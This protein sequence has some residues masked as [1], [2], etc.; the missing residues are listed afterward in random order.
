MMDYISRGICGYNSE[1]Y[2]TKS[3]HEYTTTLWSE[4]LLILSNVFLLQ[5]EMKLKL[6]SNVFEML[7]QIHTN[8]L[9]QNR[10]VVKQNHLVEIEHSIPWLKQVDAYQR[11]LNSYFVKLEETK[12]MNERSFL[13]EREI[14]TLRLVKLRD[15]TLSI[16]KGE[17]TPKIATD[18]VNLHKKFIKMTTKEPE[19]LNE[20]SDK[21]IINIIRDK[22]YT[23]KVSETFKA[24]ASS[25][26][27][28]RLMS[29]LTNKIQNVS[30]H[31]SF[32]QELG[33]EMTNMF[34]EAEIVEAM[35]KILVLNSK[36]VNANIDKEIERRKEGGEEEVCDGKDV[37]HLE[38]M[39]GNHFLCQR[40]GVGCRI[41][42]NMLVH[43]LI[44]LANGKVRWTCLICSRQF[45][46]WYLSANVY[47]RHIESH[48]AE[49]GAQTNDG[50]SEI[51]KPWKAQGLKN[52]FSK[53]KNMLKKKKESS[54]K[55]RFNKWKQDV[56]NV[57]Q[58]Y[59]QVNH[60]QGASNKPGQ[61]VKKGGSMG[62]WKKKF[63]N[64][65]PGYSGI[66]PGANQ[67]QKAGNKPVQQGK[68]WGSGGGGKKKR[69]C[70][71]ANP[72]YPSANF[73]HAGTNPGYAGYPNAKKKKK[74]WKR[75]SQIMKGSK[76]L[77]QQ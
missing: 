18:E 44:C 46:G 70:P 63:P 20:T 55:E 43:S 77:H 31:N 65:K 22:V 52:T 72:G 49:L 69:W 57:A 50:K 32:L 47:K 73:G 48:I 68:K 39:E 42:K 15:I 71:G 1:I 58:L 11:Y 66:H 14:L 34:S 76:R 59:S 54:H 28:S 62:G 56:R 4:C 10:E 60:P 17:M 3:Y 33:Q 37:G 27:H 61:Q 6:T 24:F 29:F 21:G 16:L 19:T 25:R 30:F 38:K 75:I 26:D 74:D 64:A 36:E 40:C 12:Q 9:S 53:N 13:S 23:T 7:I 45:Y 51:S 41:L 2:S 67:Q 5:R 35:E 8:S